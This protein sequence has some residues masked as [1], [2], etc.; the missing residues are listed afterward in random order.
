ML[1][2]VPSS[3]YSTSYINKHDVT[4]DDV[5]NN[6][7]NVHN[8]CKI[9]FLNVHNL[10]T[11]MKIPEFCNLIAEFDIFACAETKVTHL[12][13]IELEN[14]MYFGSRYSTVS[15]KTGGVGIFIKSNLCDSSKVID[16][17][18]HCSMCT[19][20]CNVTNTVFILIGQTL[21][22]VVY[23]V[24]EGSVYAKNDTFN[25][26]S[27][28]IADL[29][30]H[31]NVSKICLVGDFNAR[32]GSLM[33][34]NVCNDVIEVNCS[35]PDFVKDNF[36]IRNT[37]TTCP[38]RISNDH[39][40]NNYGKELLCMCNNLSL[41][42][43]NGRFGIPSSLATCRDLS[44][45]DYFLTSVDLFNYLDSLFVRTFDPLF[46]DVHN[47]LE[48]NVQSGFFVD[49]NTRVVHHQDIINN[50]PC[51]QDNNC[52][53]I[54]HRYRWSN[55]KASS[56]TNSLEGEL[57][58]HLCLRLDILLGNVDDINTDTVDELY[59]CI[60][61]M[62]KTAASDC[63]LL[64]DCKN[65]D[66]VKTK[67]APVYKKWF[68][69][70]CKEKRRAYHK[71]KNVYR[72][73]RSKHNLELLR[74][75]SKKY[76][77]A[78]NEASRVFDQGFNDKL[79]S[80]KSS[81][82]KEFWRMLCDKDVKAPDIDIKVLS[83][84]FADLNKDNNVYDDSEKERAVDSRIND[85]VFLNDLF[86]E[87]ETMDVLN[88]L[89]TCKAAGPDLLINEF[90]ISSRQLLC[91]V[92]TKLF[93]VIL[94]SGKL[95]S[96]WSESLIVPIYKN[97]GSKTDPNN[98]RGISLINCFCKLFTSLL[99][100]R[101]TRFCESIELLG[102]E[103]AGF[104][105]NFSTC[106]HIFS[107]YVL[108]WM[109]KKIIKKKLYCCFV[110]YR[111]AFDTVPRLHLWYKLLSQ[112]IN[113][114]ILNVIKELYGSAKSA[115]KLNNQC[116]P[117][118]DCNIGVR[119]GDNLSPLLF[120]LYLNDLQDHLAKAY[121]GLSESCALIEDVVQDEDT[122]VY[123]KLF[124]I[125]Y[126]DDT[127]IFAES[128]PELQAALNGMLHYCNSW[129]LGINNDKTKV[130]IFGSRPGK[131][132]HDFM[133]GDQVINVISGYTYLGVLFTCNGNYSKSMIAIKSQA[134]RAMFSL[135]KKARK[136]N[137]SIDVQLQLFDSLVVPIALYGC[138]I[139]G[140]KN[141]QI[142][143]K[144]HL[145]FCKMILKVKN[146]TNNCMVLGELGRLPLAFNIDCRMLGFWHRL[147]TGKHNKISC[148]LYKLLYNLDTQFMLSSDWLSRIKSIL[149]DS[150]LDE[151]WYDPARVQVL[152][153]V[154]FKALYKRKL[155]E[156]YQANW[157]SSLESSSKC[158]L[159]KNFKQELVLEK[160]LITLNDPTRSKLTRFRLSNHFLPIER[161]RHND[162]ARID[163][164]CNLCTVNDIGDEYHYVCVCDYFV[165]QRKKYIHSSYIKSPSVLKFCELMSTDKKVVLFKLAK[166]V[167]FIIKKFSPEG[168]GVT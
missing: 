103:Q 145:Q 68:N 135:V 90:F 27:Y 80:L 158:F 17:S 91:P 108:I 19:E 39:K 156:L 6:H 129:K 20:L 23:I 28:V 77:K 137:L 67:D 140:F 26:I 144:L 160:Y 157:K 167:S 2:V 38:Q 50:I 59:I 118:F 7:V 5:I 72:H 81:N 124:T 22:G 8:V 153:Y 13:V 159:Y 51:V 32:T 15:H 166:F 95:P 123:L 41:R 94:C 106:D 148:I 29:S 119:Q 143:E 35:I 105:K 88:N 71:Q 155:H 57:V 139:L 10:K 120:A 84:F 162:I 74:V 87:E 125:L 30:A 107:L 11:K 110:D 96:S 93:N 134:T 101:I 85:N 25:Y 136:L 40:T 109:Y 43:V 154:K 42:I 75:E 112:G 92:F 14:Y 54:K 114:K 4:D 127:V 36:G 69:N 58:S 12:D 55:D 61:E 165:N 33:D 24:P 62:F 104:R 45:V 131:H 76:K 83:D 21:L 73:C 78:L 115:V 70:D 49:S 98:Y 128:R 47:V 111:K 117:F 31:L 52:T 168:P 132:E 97:K 99:S 60:C 147:V 53:I 126:A 3:D 16:C 151:F 161:G 121:N 89:K 141:V 122:V 65:D 138:E 149:C 44:V 146:S 116:S 79:R 163:R 113:G 102:C 64:K 1:P 133:L 100:K 18:K 86:S 142:I 130:V 66:H 164:I 56:F 63:N 46:S 9:G 152:S 34:N 37:D 150:G 48:L 82:P